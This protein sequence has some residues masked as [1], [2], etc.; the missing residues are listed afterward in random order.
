M[1]GWGVRETLGPETV[2][3]A[4]AASVAAP[5]DHVI[6]DDSV[7]QL[8]ARSIDF[9]HAPAWAVETGLGDEAIIETF[10]VDAAGQIKPLGDSPWFERWRPRAEALAESVLAACGG[11]AIEFNFPG[12]LTCS[13][14]PRGLLEANPHLDD[15]IFEPGRGIGLIAIS[16][17]HAG[18]R[19]ADE[20]LPLT[21]PPRAGAPISA[22]EAAIEA[23]RD[24]A[25]GVQGQSDSITVFGSFGQLHAG[26]PGSALPDDATHRQLMVLRLGTKRHD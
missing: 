19:V 8:G 11:E 18:P 2:D 10:L 9:R 21:G 5:C 13:I 16:A 22:S 12:Y 23:F 25:V 3:A 24:P 14:T 17:E 1:A 7:T 20:A 6:V 15:E 26:P 4:F